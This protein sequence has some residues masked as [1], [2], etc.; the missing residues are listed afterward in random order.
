MYHTMENGQKP[1][2]YVH[3][4]KEGHKSGARKTVSKVLGEGLMLSQMKLCF[5]YT[6]SKQRAANT[7]KKMFH[8]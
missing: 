2:I 3:C 1:L 6:G 5:N 7:K 8:L 4:N